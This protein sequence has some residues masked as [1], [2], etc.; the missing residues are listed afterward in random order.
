MRVF[1]P[2][3]EAA[4]ADYE[5]LRAA[6]LAG[7]AV[8]DVTE[9][10]FARAGLMA[11]IA[12]PASPPDLVAT[13]HGALRAPWSAHTDP[14]LDALAAGFVLLLHAADQPPVCETQGEAR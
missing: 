4:Q 8:A 9:L 11:L 6:V 7:V 13:V 12:R 3:A 10:R 2:P 14:R 1:W 5:R